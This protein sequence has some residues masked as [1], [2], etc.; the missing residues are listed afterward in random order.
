MTVSVFS[1]H[2][3]NIYLNPYPNPNLS[4]ILNHTVTTSLFYAS[5]T[6]L[7][8]IGTSGTPLLRFWYTDV[9][10]F[11]SPPFHPWSIAQYN[12]LCMLKMVAFCTKLTSGCFM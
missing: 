9:T 8:L 10:P 1:K 7:T 3:P 12:L 4:H 2:D 11:V 5:K 6:L